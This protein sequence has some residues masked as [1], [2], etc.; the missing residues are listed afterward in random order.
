MDLVERVIEDLTEE[1]NMTEGTKLNATL[2]QSKVNAVYREVKLARNYP[3]NYNDAAID[4]DMEKYYSVIRELS[5]YDYS[6][7]GAEG[8]SQYSADGTSL[9]YSERNKYF[10]SVTPFRG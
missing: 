8:L 6:K 3:S 1:L 9:H 10:A 5:L 2:L 4:D 7:I